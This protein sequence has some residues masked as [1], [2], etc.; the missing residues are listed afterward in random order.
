MHCKLSSLKYHILW[1]EK[2]FSK[3]TKYFWHAMGGF[4]LMCYHTPAFFPRH[5]T[6]RGN[7][8]TDC[9]GQVRDNYFAYAMCLLYWWKASGKWAHTCCE[10]IKVTTTSQTLTASR[11]RQYEKRVISLHTSSMAFSSCSLSVCALLLCTVALRTSW[12]WADSCCSLDRFS[13]REDN[14]LLYICS[15]SWT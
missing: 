8:S 3:K 12:C 10:L 5:V 14:L 13:S 1:Y 11:T 9:C 15:A 2:C 6:W 7:A 4:T